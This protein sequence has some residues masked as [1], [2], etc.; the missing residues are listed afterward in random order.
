MRNPLLSEDCYTNSNSKN[1][2]LQGT[3]AIDPTGLTNLSFD[4]ATTAGSTGVDVA[5]QTVSKIGD[6]QFNASKDIIQLAK[7]MKPVTDTRHSFVTNQ[8]NTGSGVMSVN[9]KTDQF[10]HKEN[11]KTTNTEIPSTTA[12]PFSTTSIKTPSTVHSSGK[13]A[14]AGKSFQ[15]AIEI[16]P[17]IAKVKETLARLQYIP[18]KETVL[19]TTLRPETKNKTPGVYKNATRTK[20]VLAKSVVALPKTST[21]LAIDVP[22]MTMGKSV[23][24]PAA[25]A[26]K[27]TQVEQTTQSVIPSTLKSQ[28]NDTKMSPVTKQMIYNTTTIATTLF[29]TT[30]VATTPKVIS[31]TLTTEKPTTTT[32]VFVTE[33]PEVESAAGTQASL[34]DL[35]LAIQLQN[36]TLASLQALKNTKAA[37]ETPT[38]MLPVNTARSAPDYYLNYGE[39]NTLQAAPPLDYYYD[40]ATSAFSNNGLYSGRIIQSSSSTIRPIPQHTMAQSMW[41]QPRQPPFQSPSFQTPAPN[42]PKQPSAVHQS[43][44]EITQANNK[45]QHLMKSVATLTNAIQQHSLYEVLSTTANPLLPQGRKPATPRTGPTAAQIAHQRQA[46]MDRLNE[47]LAELNDMVSDMKASNTV[48]AGK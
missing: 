15:T 37:A 42:T 32:E 45:L 30:T 28:I 48:A 39:N 21:V 46:V 12:V 8:T 47:N 41:N 13:V 31:T 26:P 25:E 23:F 38:N 20:R 22:L 16:A 35:M 9:N 18:F 2:F 17:I 6:M 43:A 4:N 19:T 5:A 24:K 10:L 33:A 27:L 11:V 14:S 3:H 7:K 1:L 40:G 36:M 44:S 29:R 34:E